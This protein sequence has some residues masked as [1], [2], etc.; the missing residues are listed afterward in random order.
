MTGMVTA[1]EIPPGE[2]LY[3]SVQ[4]QKSLSDEMIPYQVA[5]FGQARERAIGGIVSHPDSYPMCQQEQSGE[6]S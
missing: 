5:F 6:W 4:R 1:L 3:V 2:P